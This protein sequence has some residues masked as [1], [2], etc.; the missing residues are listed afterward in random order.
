[1]NQDLT[2]IIL[3][4]AEGSVKPEIFEDLLNCLQYSYAM[5]FDD[6]ALWL[7]L[8]QTIKHSI[9]EKD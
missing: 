6:E 7:K 1:M 4:Q 5:N 3:D 2:K 9:T 8:Y